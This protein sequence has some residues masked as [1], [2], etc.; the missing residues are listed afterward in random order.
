M[1][2][3]CCHCGETCFSRAHDFQPHSLFL[4]LAGLVLSD[5]TVDSQMRVRGIRI[6]SP[7]AMRVTGALPSKSERSRPKHDM[8]AGIM[9]L[10]YD[11][12]SETTLLIGLS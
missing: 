3:S 1:M 5:R 11:M 9:T 7:R 4:I 6:L 12:R 2:Q 10:T 8:T